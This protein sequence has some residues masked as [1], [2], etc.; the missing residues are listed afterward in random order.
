M[1]YKIADLSLA[2]GGRAKMD[3]AWRSM[4]VLNALK[5]RYAALQP[6]KG[7][8]LSACLHLEAK[9]ACL[10]RTF[11]E[12]G[13]E[14][15]AAGSNPLSTQDDI[16]AALVDTGVSVFSRHAMSGEEYRRYLRD[17]LA[18]GP[19]VIVD[20]GADLVATVLSD[21]KE[22]I[23]AVKGASEETTSGVKRL[24]AMERQGILPFA[25]ISVNDAHSK[26]LFDNRYGTG[27]S[28]WDGFMRTTN[29]LVAGK[30]VV[31][32]GYGWCGRGAAMRARALGARVIVTEL[33]PHRAFEA[34][35]DGNELMTMAQAAPLGDIF[36]T[37]TGN[38]H[39]IRAEHFQLMKD[40]AIMG[41]AGHFDVEINKHELAAL[42]VKH[43]LA[44]ANIET[45]TLPDGRRLNLLGE[46]RLVNLACGDGHPIEIMDLSFALQLESAL[47][48]NEHGRALEAG[49]MDVPEEI[50]AAVM[51]TKLASMGLSLERM[52]D[53]QRAYMADW[54]ED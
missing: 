25:V 26:Y 29:I 2:P 54:R 19:S 5:A 45:F 17:T 10:L 37:F 35:M 53:E 12:L 44:R 41:N 18:F 16:C 47:Y 13:A 34:V 36:L 52:T 7:V 31:I 33:D 51:E 15:R 46:G 39:V 40:N 32:A 49:L 28:V 43:E 38:T 30:T 24:K 3:W 20:D 42:A 4:P 22:L 21:M 48:V 27:Q 23:P 11:K 6:L 50:D 1:D 9:T 8:K 14:V